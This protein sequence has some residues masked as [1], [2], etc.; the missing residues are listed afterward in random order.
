MKKK[1][2]PHLADLV[3]IYKREI[4]PDF[5]E[6]KKELIK[7]A[8]AG[9]IEE[10]NTWALV[11]VNS[12]GSLAGYVIFHVVNY[13]MIAGREVYVSDLLI[14]EN[15]RGTG[16]GRSLMQEVE[17]FARE[18]KCARIMLNNPKESEGYKR[19][20]YRKLGFAE[21]LVFA[22]FVKPLE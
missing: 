4:N 2:V 6:S 7:R 15:K 13:P 18:N 1:D 19:S 17:R 16:A 21:R 11:C 10:K 14:D 3:F 12:E 20:F 5:E 8:L 9:A 22:N